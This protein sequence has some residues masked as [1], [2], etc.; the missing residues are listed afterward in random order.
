MGKV[1]MFV[2]NVLSVPKIMG[3]L[4]TFQQISIQEVRSSTRMDGKSIKSLL[5]LS[6]QLSQINKIMHIKLKIQKYQTS[7]KT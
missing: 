4:L 5:I 7:L 6:I 1:S 2:G 3:G